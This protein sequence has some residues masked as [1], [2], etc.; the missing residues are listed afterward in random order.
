MKICT[1]E[2]RAAMD[3]LCQ[4]LEATGRSELEIRRDF[5]WCVPEEAVPPDLPVELG[6]G[7]IT[8]EWPTLKAIGM[9][10]ED[11]FGYGFVW[12]AAVLREVGREYP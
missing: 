8:E 4:Y 12:L 2:L 3:A 1:S 6:V 11:P 5:Y 9:G 10:T 7:S